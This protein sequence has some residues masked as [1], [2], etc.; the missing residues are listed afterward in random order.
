MIPESSGATPFGIFLLAD[1]YLAAARASLETRQAL[2][3]G[4]TRLL[5]YHSCELFLK[6]YMRSHGMLIAD[7]RAFQHDLAA[8]LAAATEMGL[9][10]KKGMLR[11]F[12][13]LEEN[14]D[15]VRVR[16]SLKTEA[17]RFHVQNAI[18]LAENVR[19][20]VRRALNFDEFGNPK[21]ALWNCSL[22]EDYPVS[23]TIIAADV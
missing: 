20:S 22:P 16:Y 13:V 9:Q 12:K 4:P 7:L 2:T 17:V 18:E 8:M 19:E 21:G 11:A 5:A 3:Y 14:N 6:A 15:Y 23:S 1:E 10:P